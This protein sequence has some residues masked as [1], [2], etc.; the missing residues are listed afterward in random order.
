[1][2]QSTVETISKSPF[3][4]GIRE[5]YP[6]DY[7]GYQSSGQKIANSFLMQLKNDQSSSKCGAIDELNLIVQNCKQLLSFVCERGKLIDYGIH[8]YGVHFISFR[9][10]VK[11]K[12]KTS[13]R[14]Q[15]NQTK[16][17]LF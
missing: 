13:F 5:I 3:W 14:I 7:W 9:L 10:N 6:N 12:E 17:V 1:M 11:F 2:N 16:Y 4:V 15:S 8:E